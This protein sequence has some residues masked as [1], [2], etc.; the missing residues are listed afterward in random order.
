MA[1]EIYKVQTSDGVDHLIDYMHLANRPDTDTMLADIAYL[2][3]QVAYI[4]SVIGGYSSV[5]VNG[6]RLTLNGSVSG[7]T[8]TINGGSVSDRKLTFSNSGASVDSGTLTMQGSVSGRTLNVTSGS[9]SGNT[10]NM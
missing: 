3:E 6:T 5:S 1:G 7:R 10:L 2:K 9:V 4:L 8:L